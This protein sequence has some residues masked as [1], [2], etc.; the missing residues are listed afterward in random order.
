MNAP[1]EMR[2][3]PTRNEPGET[4]SFDEPMDVASALGQLRTLVC[5]LGTG[6]LIVSVALS[7]FVFKQNRNLAGVIAARQRQLSQMQQNER[8]LDFTVNELVKYSAG[9]P[10]LTALLAKHGIQ[11][12]PGAAGGQP[13]PQ[14]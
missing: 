13:A 9:K 7:A 2:S 6:L 5:G 11:M 1:E 3:Q 4:P 10:E 14:P 12:T 8:V